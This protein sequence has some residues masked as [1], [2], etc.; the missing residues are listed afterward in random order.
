M[1]ETSVWSIVC[2]TLLYKRL[3]FGVPFSE[4]AVV[5]VECV[6]NTLPTLHREVHFY[7]FTTSVAP[8]SLFSTG[9]LLSGTITCVCIFLPVSFHFC[10]LILAFYI[11]FIRVV[12]APRRPCLPPPS[13]ECH[14]RPENGNAEISGGLGFDLN[15]SDYDEYI[16][17]PD[18]R[19]IHGTQAATRKRLKVYQ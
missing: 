1:W 5:C 7:D 6:T 15:P 17:H 10:F 19:Q 3:P 12:Y 18:A 4:C 16:T 8:F 2:C 11:S 13:P 14:S 9:D